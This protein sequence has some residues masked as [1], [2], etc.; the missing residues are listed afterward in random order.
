[1]ANWLSTI[2]SNILGKGT[3]GQYRPGPYY[4]AD[5]VLGAGPGRLLNWWQSGYS[6]KPYGERSAMVE[7][8]QSAYSQTVAMCPGDHWRSLA[9]GGRERVTNS[10]LSRI[11]KKPNDYQS[12]SDFLLNLTRNL[13]SASGEA[14]AVGIR[15]DRNEIS[16]LHLMRSGK[17]LIAEDG[18]VFYHLSGNEIAEQRFDFTDPIPARDVLHVRL[19]TPRHPLKGEGPIMAAA[20][21]LAMSGAALNQQIAFY[22][23]QARPSF[24]LET[25][26]QLT[27]DQTTELRARWD[28]QTKGD[29]AGGT[30]ILAW[31]LKAKAVTST[32]NDGQLAEMLKM[33]EQNIALAFRVPLQILGIG[34][35]PFASTES[36]MASWKASGLGFALNHIEE[37]FGQLFNLKGVPDEYLEFD[38]NILL[39]SSFKERIEAL[40]NGTRRLYTINEA[41]A[42]E[43]LPSVTGGDEIRVQQQDVPLSYGEKLQPPQPAPAPTPANDDTADEDDPAG[44]AESNER[45]RQSF[46]SA[47]A[48]TVAV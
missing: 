43:G 3:E 34:G 21:D 16:E 36:L 45:A 5:G 23:N 12:I 33:T 35:T 47:Y 40:T 2:F 10:A 18:S 20:L 29:N 7:A 39:R 4:L 19:H 42:I 41:R 22:L 25:D 37:A 28:E 48:R 15:N 31:G 11:I 24:M 17:P 32:A 1:M 44:D 6:L 46:R 9:N 14:F 38:T 13:Y 30:P 8:C 27:K 26:Q